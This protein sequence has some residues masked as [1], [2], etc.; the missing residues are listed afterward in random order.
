[1]QKSDKVD[2]IKYANANPSIGAW[3]VADKFEIGRAQVQTILQKK[4]S[5]LMSFES[6]EGPQ[7]NLKWFRTGKSTEGVMG[8]MQLLQEFQHTCLRKNASRGGSDCC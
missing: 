8:V 2:A 4:E 5:L 6:H 7:T 3:K 1:M